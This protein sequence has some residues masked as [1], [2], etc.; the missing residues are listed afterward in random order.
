M[1]ILIALVALL[2]ATAASGQ[3]NMSGLL[4]KR[5]QPQLKMLDYYSGSVDGVI[6]PLTVQAIRTFEVENELNVDGFLTD[7]ELEVLEQK[8]MDLTIDRMEIR[9]GGADFYITFPQTALSGM[10]MPMFEIRADRTQSGKM[11]LILIDNVFGP[12]PFEYR[13][14]YF[15]ADDSEKK[16]DLLELTSDISISLRSRLYFACASLSNIDVVENVLQESFGTDPHLRDNFSRMNLLD[17]VHVAE[18]CK[19]AIYSLAMPRVELH[20][21]EKSSM[22][23]DESDNLAIEGGYQLSHEELPDEAVDLD[24]DQRKLAEYERQLSE[25][26]QEIFERDK[27]IDDLENELAAAQEDG[28]LASENRR[29]AEELERQLNAEVVSN[30]QKDQEIIRL[31]TEISNVRDELG[32]EFESSQQRVTELRRQLD[33]A[34]S[35]IADQLEGI[36]N[37]ERVLELKQQIASLN[38][39]NADLR[40]RISTE[41]VALEE[42][43][44][45]ERQLAAS[46]AS[47]ADLRQEIEESYVSNENH[48]SV[49]NDLQSRIAEISNQKSEVERRLSASSKTIADLREVMEKD[50]VP[51]AELAEARRQINAL[52]E[53]IVELQEI[54]SRLR[55][56]MME[57]DRLFNNFRDDC[58]AISECARAM[59]LE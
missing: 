36:E 21:P 14:F 50:Y 3:S 48:R 55:N 15:F 59:Q 32:E 45:V 13:T 20:T 49:V 54:T 4:E 6:G 16:E 42:F 34:N 29:T 35:T 30:A 12:L 57:S 18:E 52:N 19:E 22:N 56:R 51:Q 10:D 47:I 7:Q 1:R 38:E 24:G 58:R 2:L 25:A 40:E 43:R 11:A 27:R 26:E 17:L 8:V 23:I 39:A 28:S 31:E 5:I 37:D 44:E 9:S 33:A 53:T 41:Y 46:T